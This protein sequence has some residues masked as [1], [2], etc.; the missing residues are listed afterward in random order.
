MAQAQG[1]TIDFNHYLQLMAKFMDQPDLMDILTIREPPQQVQGQGG[2]QPPA[3]QGPP[4][5][6]TR[7]NMPGRT[8]KGN[9]QNMISSMLGV[10]PGG[11]SSNGAPQKVGA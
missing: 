4:Q 11:A 5:P 3:P 1:V 10:N 7:I 6:Q 2:G 9:E 8:Q